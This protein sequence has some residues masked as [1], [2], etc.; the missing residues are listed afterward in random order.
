M[1]NN[2]IASETFENQSVENIYAL[3][4]PENLYVPPN[5]LLISLDK[6]EGPL[7][8]LLYLIQHNNMNILDIPI[9]EITQQYLDYVELM[10]THYL[11]LAAEYLVMAAVLM[12][13]KSRLLLPTPDDSEPEADPRARL[14]AQLQEYALYKKAAEELNSLP[15]VGRDILPIAIQTPEFII[16]IMPPDVPLNALLLAMRDVM[17]RASFSESHQVTREPLSIRER[18]QIILDA[19]KIN[20][21]I[22]FLNL[23]SL[24]EGRAGVV[25]T[26]LAILELVKE[27]LI[28][29]VQKQDFETIKI[30]KVI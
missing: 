2:D 4:I 1:L 13:I 21:H 20:Q 18:M 30:L 14:I 7:D 8:L 28:K 5:A 29:I 26:L 12:E 16:K 22:D 25:V 11:D 6:F 19:L 9:A 23:F 27:S 17:E 3:E 15:R 24:E 10:K